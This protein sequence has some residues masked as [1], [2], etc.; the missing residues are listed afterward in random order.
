MES[1][2]HVNRTHTFPFPF[3]KSVESECG[4]QRYFT[5]PCNFHFNTWIHFKKKLLRVTYYNIPQYIVSKGRLY[6]KKSKRPLFSTSASN[7]ARRESSK[8]NFKSSQNCRRVKLAALGERGLKNCT[9]R[10]C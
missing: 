1:L 9:L 3:D 7:L 6:K 2:K 5:L 10:C 8:M 4:K